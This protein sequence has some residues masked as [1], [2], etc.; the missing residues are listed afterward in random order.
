[1]NIHDSLGHEAGDA[2]LK[3]VA[4]RLRRCLRPE[5]S[6]ARFGGDEFVVLIEDIEGPEVAVR[7]AERFTE[8][9]KG[10]FFLEGREL[11]APS[12]IGIGLGDARTKTPEALLMDADTAMY[13]AKEE[14]GT[15]RV[16]DPDM[17]KRAKGRLELEADLR[18]TLEAPSERLPVYY[19]PM[20]SIPDG[21]IVGIEALLRWAHPE[22]GL[23]VPPGFIPMA[24]ETGLIVPMGRWV[25]NE[26]CRRARE[27]QERYPRN[28]QLTIAV[29]ISARQ[30]RYPQLVGEVEDALRKSALD[31]GSLTL[32]ITESVL[33]EDEGSSAGT[34]Q[35]LKELGVRL[36]I[37]D[38]G[39]GYSWLS[40]LR[41][42]PVDQLKL[43]RVL[44]GNLDTDDKNLAIV[45]AAV[46]L[47]H[48]LGI[49]VVAEG[50]ETHQEFDKLSKL[51]CDVGQGDYWW[52]PHLPRETEE[53]LASNHPPLPD[54]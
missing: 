6:L 51:G 52:G 18:R 16:F 49:E 45:R 2:L 43:D 53:L 3:L 48:A 31:P 42:L 27:W 47:G 50:V 12:S 14:G 28:A 36:A 25:L 7:V 19:Q 37:D 21:T 23:L 33:V 35:R 5:D 30:L 44:V 17:Y 38:F 32:D 39:V 10:P 15:F 24:E 11:F 1:M 26:A 13:R 22:Q 8:E 9:L 54:Q 40:Y 41:Y 20:V 34:L 46:D 4:Q 29:N